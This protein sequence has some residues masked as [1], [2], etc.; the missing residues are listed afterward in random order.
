MWK[1]DPRGKRVS[2]DLSLLRQF[3]EL[4]DGQSAISKDFAEQAGTDG[5]A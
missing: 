1:A 5:L 2:G 4:V 3:H